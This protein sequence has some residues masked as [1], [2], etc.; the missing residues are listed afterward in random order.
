MQWVTV[1]RPIACGFAAWLVILSYHIC[2]QPIDWLMV[3]TTYVVST[4][5]MVLNGY[6]DRDIDTKKGIRGIPNSASF[7][8]YA[9]AWA[10]AAVVTCATVTILRPSYCAVLSWVACFLSLSYGYVRVIPLINNLWVA[11]AFCLLLSP[12]EQPSIHLFWGTFLFILARE[13]MKDILDVDHDFPFKFT[14]P[15][16]CGV[17][18]AEIVI[19]GLLGITVF[20]LY[21]L[22]RPPEWWQVLIQPIA[23]QAGW[24]AQDT[25]LIL[26]AESNSDFI[27]ISTIILF[28]LSGMIQYRWRA[29]CDKTIKLEKI[30]TTREILVAMDIGWFVQCLF[31]WSR[32]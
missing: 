19:L 12:H 11:A 22:S 4:A 23:H 3:W 27:V 13:I 16:L 17:P 18:T 5:A 30:P 7:Y 1:L 24:T 8:N 14:I 21:P 9:V 32:I 28:F 10:I 20:P 31:L 15:L 26:T 25:Q 2:H 29:I 6:F